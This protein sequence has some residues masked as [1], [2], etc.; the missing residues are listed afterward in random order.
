MA[1]QHFDLIAI[2]GGSG[3][4]A[5]AARAASHGAKVALIET[6][7][8]GGTCVNVG[9]VPKKAMWF[10]AQV[11]EAMTLAPDYGFDLNL[12]GL[13][14]SQLVAVREQYISNIHKFYDGYLTRLD[15]THLQGFGRFS[16]PNQVEVNEQQYTADHIIIAPGGQPVWP[17][18]PGAEHGIDSDGFFELQEQPETVTIVGS[19]Y[20]AVEIAGVLNA[21]G[22]KV[23]LVI[24]K[25]KVLRDF[26]DMLSDALM[27][28]METQGIEVI[29][30]ATPSAVRLDADGRRILNITKGEIGPADCLIWAVGR[31]PLTKDLN[32]EAAG[33]EFDEKGFIP[34]DEYQNTNVDGIYAV[35][36][37]TGRAQLTPVAVAAGRRLASRLFNHLPNLHLSYNNIPTVIFSHPP[38]GTIGMTEAEAIKAYGE[39]NIKVYRSKFTPMYTAL[40]QHKQPAHM[41]LIT[42]GRQER[43]IGCHIL[44]QGADEMLQGFA[45]AITM[46]ATKADFDNT[47]A[48]HPT[49]AEE[50]VTMT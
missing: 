45:V 29:T 40:T 2:G 39:D 27:T 14:W 46:G 7:A 33:V 36:D 10:A 3:G 17:N 25:T 15:I 48:I 12:S 34:V 49:S 37:V 24:R 5:S 6:K 30:E 13:D 47:L 42:E 44:G 32:L 31:S 4:I 19:G 18:I 11:A 38:I 1:E 22:S 35:G 23:K 20:I 50:F 9:C 8:L 43:V 26:D 16:G 21:L 41:K 28:A